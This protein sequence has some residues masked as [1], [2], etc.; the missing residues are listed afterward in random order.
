M[1]ANPGPLGPDS[2]RSLCETSE[3][4]LPYAGLLLTSLWTMVTEEVYQLVKHHT[5][6]FVKQTVKDWLTRKPD[7]HTDRLEESTESLEV[8]DVTE[9]RR[10]RIQ[11]RRRVKR[12]K[13][14]RRQH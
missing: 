6:D 4:L 10:G 8:T 11:R 1:I 2:W 3:N 14:T 7:V 13:T 12:T 9:V 5:V